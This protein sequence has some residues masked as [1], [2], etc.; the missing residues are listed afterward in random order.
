MRRSQPRRTLRRAPQRNLFTYE[1]IQRIQ[2]AWRARIAE[3]RGEKPIRV[4]IRKT[5]YRDQDGFVVNQIFVRERETAERVKEAI[6]DN[7]HDRIDRILRDEYER[8]SQ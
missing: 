2:G 1:D 8:K 7:R 5:T 3:E 4:S 6:K